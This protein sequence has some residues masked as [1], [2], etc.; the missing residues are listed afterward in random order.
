MSEKT[1]LIQ[2]ALVVANTPEHRQPFTGWV[3]IEGDRVSALGE[4][5]PEE[6]SAARTIDGHGYALMPGLINAHVHSHS[7]LTRGSAEGLRL[8]DW[9]AAIE[10]EQGR[11]DEEQAYWGALATYAEALLSGTTALVDMCLFPEAAR[12]AAEEIDIRAVIAPYTADGKPIT[13][14]LERAEALLALGPAGD[15]RVMAWVG[16][17]DLESC[18]DAQVE[19]G[20]A[21]AIAHET[22]L[23]LH[24]A[25]SRQA[26]EATRQRTGRSP[27]AQLEVLGALGRRSLLA[28]CV[29]AD[30]ADQRTI[31]GA[32]AHVVHCPHSNLKLGSGIAPVPALLDEGVN[33]ALG[34]DGA[35]A[36]NRLDMFDVMKFASLLHKGFA[37]DPSVLPPSQILDMATAGRARALGIKAGTLAP[38]MLADLVLVRLDRLHLQPATPE[39]IITNLVHAARGSDVDTV[40]VGG[41]ITVERG[42][43]KT[44]DQRSILAHLT[45][46][47]HELLADATS[48]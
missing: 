21:L 5:A 23:H 2:D 16:L 7:S 11:L 25:E 33:V 15:G 38:G 22:G 9:L 29:W 42:E 24:C 46:I 27:I 47:G 36:N 4:G 19:A 6:L 20:A 8:E 35:K 37:A 18:S 34:T 1:L 32:G 30:E 43:L 39:T 48:A 14:S 17:H 44:I 26:V 45:E 3:G 28:H 40:I 13:P 12:R 10:R 41:R 31:A